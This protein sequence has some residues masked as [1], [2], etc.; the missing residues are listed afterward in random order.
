MVASAMNRSTAGFSLIELLIVIAI[1]GVLASI[2]YP[3]YQDSVAKTRR[4]DAASALMESVQALERYYTVNH[5][6]TNSS[7]NLPAIYP[8]KAPNNGVTYYNIAVAGTPTASTFTLR[9][10]PTGAMTGDYCGNF[11][12][13]QSGVLSLDSASSGYTVAK[14]WRR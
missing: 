6:Y 7:G 9:A 13:D 8:T 14:C 4:N 10:S 3:S 12:I 5:R 1:I 2:A 11:Q